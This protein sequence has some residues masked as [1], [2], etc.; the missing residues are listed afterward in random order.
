MYKVDVSTR[1]EVHLIWKRTETTERPS[2]SHGKT[3]TAHTQ[4]PGHAGL[5]IQPV[6]VPWS[7]YMAHRVQ[8]TKGNTRTQT[9]TDYLSNS[10]KT[11]VV[12]QLPFIYIY[13][14]N[15]ELSCKNQRLIYSPSQP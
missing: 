5:S 4:W 2:G 7:T 10:W 11:Q 1:K 9:Q 14:L 15:A 12:N 6:T 13:M 8:T 3:D